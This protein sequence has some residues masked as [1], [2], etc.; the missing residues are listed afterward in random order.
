MLLDENG[1]PSLRLGFGSTGAEPLLKNTY[2][3]SRRWNSMT[4]SASSSF[5]DRHP[6]YHESLAY[7]VPPRAQIRSAQLRSTLFK[8]VLLL[9]ITPAAR[10]TAPSSESPATAAST[11]S[12]TPIAVEPIR[13]FGVGEKRWGQVRLPDVLRE[14]VNILQS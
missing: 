14:Q 6:R 10:L 9:S 4:S 13:Q 5:D 1:S 2:A 11:T 7:T 3:V 8:M 12:S